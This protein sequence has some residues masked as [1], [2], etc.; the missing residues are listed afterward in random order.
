M[1]LEDLIIV[2]TLYGI[3]ALVVIGI[4]YVLCLIVKYVF[5]WGVRYDKYSN[6]RFNKSL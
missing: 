5:F 1:D 4:F 3:G 2:L 6:N